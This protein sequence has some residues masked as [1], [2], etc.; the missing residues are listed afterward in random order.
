MSIRSFPSDTPARDVADEL[1]ATGAVI[2][3][4][5]AKPETCDTIASD[6]R[7]YFD[8][9]GK[10][11]END[12][13]GY[14]TLRLSAILARSRASADLIGDARVMSIIDEVLLNHCINY[15]IGST[16]GIEIQPGEAAQILHRDDSMYPMR[17]T[18]ME[19]QVGV[20][21]A[22]NDF[23]VENGATQVVPG[24]HKWL[25]DRDVGPT[26]VVQHDMPKGSALLYMGSTLHGGGENRSNAPRMGLINTYSLGWLRQEVNQYLT[27]PKDIAQSY[28]DHIQR[29]IG[30]Q[31]HGSHLGWYPGEPDNIKG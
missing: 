15:R 29:L 2:L 30:Y 19:W 21:W 20:M 18:G 7:D 12:F 23:T 16:T 26:E 9:E 27:I 31:T 8:S 28:P 17:V 5:Q 14:K 4:N 22:L 10:Y 24:S 6:L 13:N 25:E 1:K 3:S 11:S